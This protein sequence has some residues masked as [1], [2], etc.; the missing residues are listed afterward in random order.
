MR[1]TGVVWKTTLLLAAAAQ[2]LHLPLPAAMAWTTDLDS[3]L[4]SHV[5][6]PMILALLVALIL[7]TW[8]I[9]DAT[10]YFRPSPERRPASGPSAPDTTAREIFD[11]I[12]LQ[13][14]WALGQ[15]KYQ[16]KLVDKIAV[17][18]R[19]AAAHSRISIFGRIHNAPLIER[20]APL[21]WAD[22]ELD[23][24]TCYW[25]KNTGGA[26]TRAVGSSA[27]SVDVPL[28]E[29][30]QFAKADIAAIWP[31]ASWLALHLDKSRSDR[32]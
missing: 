12:L 1:W 22:A 26:N 17:M 5:Q 28:Y 21:Y 14:K 19:E 25:Q 3:W 15:D 7:G 29:D 13:S 30:V 6:S 27:S 8:I 18:L 31:P 11:Y 23:P 2:F 32:R 24:T 4:Y 10:A 9:P 16:D 20:I